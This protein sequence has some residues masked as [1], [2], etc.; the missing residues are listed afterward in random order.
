MLFRY[1]VVFALALLPLSAANAAELKLVY[2]AV[3]HVQKSDALPVL[4][5]K[6]HLMG[7]GAFRGIAIFPGDQLARHQY[8]GWFDLQEGSGPFHGYARWVF[9]DGATLSA[10]YDGAAKAIAKGDAEVS[11]TFADFSGTGRFENVKG[12]GSFTGRR[13]EPVNKGGT[14]YLKGALSLQTAD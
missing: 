13:F 10:R 4:D 9:P 1:L 7:I 2:Q 11:A 5:D 3:M 14:T 12:E 8:D 6:K